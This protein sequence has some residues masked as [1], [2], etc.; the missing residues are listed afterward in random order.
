MHKTLPTLGNKKEQKQNK[1]YKNNTSE[2]HFLLKL[3]EVLPY[4]MKIVGSNFSK[5]QKYLLRI[6][7]T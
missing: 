5:N 6:H 2:V 3:I 1:F 4:Y 7:Q